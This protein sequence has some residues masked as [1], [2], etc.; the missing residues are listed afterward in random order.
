LAGVG[1]TEFLAFFDHLTFWENTAVGKLDLVPP[2]GE[3][4]FTSSD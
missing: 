2:S 3:K 1:I 4:M